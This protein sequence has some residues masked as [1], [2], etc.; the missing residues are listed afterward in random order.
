MS[1]ENF[2]VHLH[3]QIETMDEKQTREKFRLRLSGVTDGTYCFSIVCDK[4]FFELA[5]FADIE[6]GNLNLQIKMEKH[7]KMID[8]HFH[9]EGTV[10]AP[11]DRCLLPVTIPLNFDEHLVVKLV[12]EVEE[13]INDMDDYIWVLEDTA[14][15]L[16]IF[17]FVYESIVLALPRR[18]THADDADGNPT[19]DPVIMKKLEELSGSHKS[20][21]DIDPRWEALKTIKID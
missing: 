8:L 16:D 3:P 20:K 7:E 14:Y 1:I 9:F 6:D 10:I 21:D 19:C 2:H 13:G 4:M 17:H 15:E 5:E 11:C 18:I 12:A